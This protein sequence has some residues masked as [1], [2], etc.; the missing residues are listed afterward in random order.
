[1]GHNV[2]SYLKRLFSSAL[3]TR[4]I[5][6]HRILELKET[7]E[8]IQTTRGNLSFNDEETDTK[9]KVFSQSYQELMKDQTAGIQTCIEGPF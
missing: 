4:L 1:M 9:N 5:Q 8:A 2:G 3:G 7:Q 6:V